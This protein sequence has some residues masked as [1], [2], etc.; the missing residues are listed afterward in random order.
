MVEHA[1]ENCSNADETLPDTARLELAVHTRR[2]RG[3]EVEEIVATHCVHRKLVE[4][5]RF[6]PYHR[7]F[8]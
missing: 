3:C 6:I 7:G 4:A 8:S 1:R 2:G 5:E